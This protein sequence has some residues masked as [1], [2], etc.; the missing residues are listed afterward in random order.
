MAR[1]H[2]KHDELRIHLSEF[3]KG[4]E[5]HSLGIKEISVCERHVCYYHECR[6]LAKDRFRHMMNIDGFHD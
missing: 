1:Q 6:D 5:E 4:L 2:F 3:D